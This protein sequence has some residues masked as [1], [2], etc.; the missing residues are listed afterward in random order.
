MNDT[1]KIAEEMLLTI[2]EGYPSN[3]IIDL[4]RIAGQRDDSIGHLSVEE[5]T[6]FCKLKG[7]GESLVRYGKH[8]AYCHNCGIKHEE[9]AE[10]VREKLK[11]VLDA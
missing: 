9:I 4:A 8:I 6:D 10:E 7:S 2:A 11:R 3:V 1:P 5:I